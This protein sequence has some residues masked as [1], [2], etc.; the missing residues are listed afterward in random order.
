[1]SA[2]AFTVLFCVLLVCAFFCLYRLQQG[3]TAPD[4]TVAIDILGTLVV[5][6][7]CLMALWTGHGFYMNVAIAWALLSFIGTIAL[8]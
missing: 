8:A 5:G 7:C 2:A 6:F 1:M 3:P 4:R